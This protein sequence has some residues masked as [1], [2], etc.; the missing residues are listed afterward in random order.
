MN[1]RLEV[2]TGP[3][4]SGKSEELLRRLRRAE[5]AGKKVIVAK[6]DID[7]RYDKKK[8][9]S[10]N[11]SMMDAVLVKNSMNLRIQTVGYD[12]VGIDEVQ[13]LEGDTLLEDLRKMAVRQN[14]IA[15]GLDMT[16]RLEPFGIMPQLLAVAE[17][18]DKLT[19]ICHSCGEEAT[20]TQRLIDGKPASL[21]GPTVLVGGLDSYEARCPRCWEPG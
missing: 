10:H 9:V 18:I 15:S 21:T 7:S 19:A 2:I 1:G 4:Y 3:M 14:V 12:V 17:R 11:G 16:F 20:Q 13:F 6:P 8:V 5:I